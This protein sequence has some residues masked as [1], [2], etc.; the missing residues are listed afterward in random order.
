MSIDRPTFPNEQEINCYDGTITAETCTDPDLAFDDDPTTAAVFGQPGHSVTAANADFILNGD[1]NLDTGGQLHFVIGVANNSPGTV[2]YN[3]KLPVGAF[4]L[5]WTMTNDVVEVYHTN[6]FSFVVQNNSENALGAGGPT[7]GGIFGVNSCVAVVWAFAGNIVVGEDSYDV[8]LYVNGVFVQGQNA[9]FPYGNNGT[10]GDLI[11]CEAVY[12]G[13]TLSLT[14]TDTSTDNTA[15]AT[16]TGVDIPHALG[17]LVGYFGFG[18]DPS[19]PDF[20]GYGGTRIEITNGFVYT[21]NDFVAPRSLQV[22]LDQDIWL[23]RIR[24]FANGA[25]AAY[26]GLAYLSAYGEEAYGPPPPDVPI[27]YIPLPV[28]GGV[29]ELTLDPPVLARGVLFL[30]D[31]LLDPL[32]TDPTQYGTVNLYQLQLYQATLP[33]ASEMSNPTARFATLGVSALW[34]FPWAA[35]A[36][37]PFSAGAICYL[38]RPQMLNIGIASKKADEYG[39]EAVFLRASYEYERTETLKLQ[40]QRHDMRAVQLFTA[41]QLIV[42]PGSG[43][44]P[45]LSGEQQYIAPS[46][47]DTAPYVSLVA[48]STFADKSRLY[49]WPKCKLAGNLTED[50]DRTKLSVFE[51]TCEPVWDDTYNLMDGQTGGIYE[52][53]FT[54]GGP[55][56]PL[57]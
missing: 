57:S 27:P 44:D 50:L 23:C 1:A 56:N 20:L 26:A 46:L 31:S 55:A 17:S 14:M 53:V 21:S 19:G 47:S 40:I 51:V 38:D 25:G 34:L 9:N 37:Y 24:Y 41:G 7:G 42:I 28:D 35:N 5:T 48:Q 30:P 11:A 43:N 3:T 6:C 22:D 15:T 29:S 49:V 4:N 2:Y 8:G 13:S 54:A 33:G 39:G 10:E 18:A 12:D 52:M 36:S 16:F 45:L 32:P